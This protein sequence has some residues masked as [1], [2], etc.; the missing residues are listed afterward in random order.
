MHA[1][2]TCNIPKLAVQDATQVSTLD[3]MSAKLVL[4]EEGALE[5][6]TET[7]R[8]KGKRTAAAEA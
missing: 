2:Q 3:L 1:S 8:P 6:L 7:L 5:A 4:V